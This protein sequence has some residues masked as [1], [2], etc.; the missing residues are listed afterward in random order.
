MKKN[1]IF[2]TLAIGIVMLSAT[3]LLLPG[4]G[5]AAKA[6]LAFSGG[7]DGGTF[8]YFSNAIAI[9]LSRNL[10][11]IDLS[12]MVS[13]G[14][15]ENLRRVNSGDA[16]F[17]IVYAGDLFLGAN[18]R[19]TNDTIK[20]TNAHGMAYLYGA[21][22][23][24]VVLADS[25][26]NEVKDLEGKRFAAGPAGSGAAASAQRFFTALG[27]WDKMKVEYIGYSEGASALGDKKIDA[28]WVFAGYPNASVIQAAAS[29]KIKL[30]NLVEAAKASPFFTEHPY[31]AE[32]T[33][34]AGT[35]S[36]VD[37]D[38]QSIQDS[39]IWVAGKH[40]AADV[41]YNAL[42]DTFSDEGLAAMVAATKAAQS[43]KVKDGVYGIATPLH[44]G[45]IKFW[46]EKG[47]T[48]TDAQAGK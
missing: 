47:L 41:V 40:V 12:N 3:L 39:A 1:T 35:Y 32:L 18:G 4:S 33:I 37:Y 27:L 44:Q 23:H 34:P 26:I 42:K 7:P 17:G 25:G 45:A 19:L 2:F 36:G 38:V 28:M 15:V 31:Y 13:A 43:M 46:T 6:R 48:I 20:Y 24:L 9:R 30:L 10:P 21:P 29:N 14:S 5:L 8:Q 22:A 16:D 11:D